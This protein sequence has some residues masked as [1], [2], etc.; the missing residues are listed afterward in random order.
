MT[1]ILA[2]AAIVIGAALVTLF[3]I[4]ERPVA[5]VIGL[6]LSIAV[7]TAVLIAATQGNVGVNI[8]INLGTSAAAPP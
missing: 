4:K 5:A 2:T 8:D 1:T 6:I 7:A 3:L